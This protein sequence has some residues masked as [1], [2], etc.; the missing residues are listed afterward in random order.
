MLSCA[1]ENAVN[2]KNN[3]NNQNDTSNNNTSDKTS[4]RLF[5]RNKWILIQTAIWSQSP[6]RRTTPSANIFLT[7][8][9]TREGLRTLQATARR[10]RSIPSLALLTT[11]GSATRGDA[12]LTERITSTT[13]VTVICDKDNLA[14]L[15]SRH[16]ILTASV[17]KYSGFRATCTGVIR[18]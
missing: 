9:T 7:G 12:K 4:I 17:I 15:T 14:S 1:C 18:F 6:R 10:R 3:D 2:G 16:L 8:S 13:F 5:R 11:M